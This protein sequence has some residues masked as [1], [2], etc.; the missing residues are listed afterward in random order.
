VISYR[1][2]DSLKEVVVVAAFSCGAAACHRL[3]RHPRLGDSLAELESA[4]SMEWRPLGHTM[5]GPQ[6][7]ADYV[8]YLT[9]DI[10]EMSFPNRYYG[11]A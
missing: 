11:I 5:R 1:C 10:S 6:L 8:S 4:H 3:R 9:Y 7:L 2:S